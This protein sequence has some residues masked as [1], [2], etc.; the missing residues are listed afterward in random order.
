MT[1]KLSTNDIYEKEAELSSTQYGQNIL[2]VRF[3]HSFRI[4]PVICLLMYSKDMRN[5]LLN[6]KNLLNF[7]IT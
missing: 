4:F 6:V 3:I 7:T 1:K 2:R 5:V